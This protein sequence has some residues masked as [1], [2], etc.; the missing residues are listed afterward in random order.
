MEQPKTYTVEEIFEINRQYVVPLFQRPYVWQKEQWK[1]LWDDII[2]CVDRVVECKR[3]NKDTSD[4]D[5]FL[6]AAV[7]NPVQP[8]FHRFV[9]Q[10]EIIDGQQRLTTLQI[11]LAVFRDFLSETVK[12]NKNKY[13]EI[14]GYVEA[15]G[16]LTVNQG[17]LIKDYS[18][19]KIFPT[20]SDKDIFE[21]VMSAK[22]S[23]SIE[24]AYPLKRK[25]YTRDKFESRPFF[26]AAYLFFAE[27]LKE[28]FSKTTSN[29][30]CDNNLFEENMEIM[31]DIICRKS[32]LI[33][34]ELE[35]KDDPQ[36][37]FETLNARGM[38]LLPSDLI[39]NFVF[40][41][42]TREKLD[43]AKIYKK[44]WS[45][46]D[47]RLID[48]PSNNKEKRFWKQKE[49]QGRSTRTRLDL[50]LQH[51]VQYR[52]CQYVDSGH[53][54]QSFRSWWKKNNSNTEKELQ[55]IRKHSDVFAD[56]FIPSNK[57]RIDFFIKRIKILDTNTIYSILLLLLVDEK[58]KIPDGEL[59]SIITDIES[60]LIRRMICNLG[61]KNY[62]RFFLTM[63]KKLHGL[64]KITRKEI[65]NLLLSGNGDAV[66]WP[67]EKEFYTAWLTKPVY[68]IIKNGRCRMILLA[69]NRHMESVKQEN[70][71]FNDNLTIEHILPQS[72]KN[73]SDWNTIDEQD[74]RINKDMN[75][76][77]NRSVLLHTFGNL[78][79]LTQKL[80]SEV[81][82]GD[83]GTKREKIAEQSS[84]RLNSYFQI[85]SSESNKIVGSGDSNS[86]EWNEKDIIER[87]KNLFK[88]AKTIWPHPLDQE[89]T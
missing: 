27:N 20:N 9:N 44:Y 64:E 21:F 50:F 62:N 18:Q 67:N 39:R 25:K 26:V 36:I 88:I 29:N 40:M 1:N 31:Y 75:R 53:L 51:Y 3:D 37:I 46:Y 10:F 57:K 83:Y 82:N 7:I 15:L 42:A 85:K 2:D 55:E 22:S 41:Q 89:K 24:M 49:R 78:T 66:R 8:S 34:I 79:L 43:I 56:F 38:A 12:E 77:E 30:N 54:Y 32:L 87:G 17:K 81:S 11:I 47:E 86:D 73:S 84:L 58:Q 5:K 48:K 6:G 13:K 72:W 23:E 60:Y 65:Q 76:E 19:F 14:D 71:N 59:D 45:D 69:I 74:D 33:I 52:S 28:F 68:E 35:K 63:L 80:N 70:E 61:T 16:R 4:I